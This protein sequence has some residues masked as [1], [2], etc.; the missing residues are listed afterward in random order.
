MG[1]LFPTNIIGE[2]L[3]LLLAFLIG[4]GFGFLLEAAGFTN[5]RKLA[6]VFYGYDFVVLKVFF[7]AAITAGIGIYLLSY[8]GYM[9]IKEIFY[10]QTYWIPTLVG[11]FIMAFGFIIGGFCPGTSICAAATGKIDAIVFVGGALIGIFFYAFTYESL[12]MN[13]RESGAMGKVN[14]AEWL[15]IS[16]GLFLFLL[17]VVA[18]IAFYIVTIIQQRVVLKRNFKL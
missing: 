18:A 12:W 5:T 1:P 15:G 17:T 11:G 13:L 6:G 4:I 9:D 3:N 7:S 8:Y 2:E 10:P 14:I 16:Q